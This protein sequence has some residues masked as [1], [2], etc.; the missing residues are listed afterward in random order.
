MPNSCE[1]FSGDFRSE[2]VQPR[3]AAASNKSGRPARSLKT[4]DEITNNYSG[5]Y[6]PDKLRVEARVGVESADVGSTYRSKI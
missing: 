3:T 2:Y 1:I 5:I 4:N 6:P